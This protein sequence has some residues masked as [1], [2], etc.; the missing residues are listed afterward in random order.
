MLQCCYLASV[1]FWWLSLLLHLDMKKNVS[2]NALITLPKQSCTRLIFFMT[3][4]LIWIGFRITES[5]IQP[6]KMTHISL[7]CRP[8]CMDCLPPLRRLASKGPV[9]CTHNLSYNHTSEC[10]AF[11]SMM[12][13][14][15]F[16]YK[17]FYKIQGN[18]HITVFALDLH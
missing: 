10:A 4:E 7:C 17:K 9:I 12:Q 5:N 1:F 16:Q 13:A 15:A 8:L 18:I 2:P 11:R 3:S 14:F 6:F